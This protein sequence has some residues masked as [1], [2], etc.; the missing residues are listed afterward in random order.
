MGTR[1]SD[2]APR[3]CELRGGTREIDD[4]AKIKDGG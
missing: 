3:R 1:T 2:A 4:A